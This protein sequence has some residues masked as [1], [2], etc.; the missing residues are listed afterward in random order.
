MSVYEQTDCL[1]MISLNQE[2]AQMLQ[3]SRINLKRN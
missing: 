3:H 1:K 2:S